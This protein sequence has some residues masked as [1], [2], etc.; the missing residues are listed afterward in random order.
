MGLI[1][2]SWLQL[3]PNEE[4]GGFNEDF[5]SYLQRIQN[6]RNLKHIPSEVLEQW[7]HPLHSDD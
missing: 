3:K 4:L 6:K 1:S 2:E 7:I 5:N